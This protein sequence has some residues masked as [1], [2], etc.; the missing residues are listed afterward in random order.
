MRKEMLYMETGDEAKMRNVPVRVPLD[1]FVKHLHKTYFSHSNSNL[2]LET[3][4]P[5]KAEI[6]LR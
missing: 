2:F 3:S 6:C 1:D 4:G 5:K